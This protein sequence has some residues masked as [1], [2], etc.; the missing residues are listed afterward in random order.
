MNRMSK[1][2]E[3]YEQAQ[4]SQRRVGKGIEGFGEGVE[5]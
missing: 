2:E 1:E 5:D 3:L 4:Y